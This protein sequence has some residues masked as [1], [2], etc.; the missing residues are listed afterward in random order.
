MRLSIMEILLL[1]HLDQRGCEP[2]V[3][4]NVRGVSTDT[5]SLKNADLFV[6]LRGEN[7]DGHM[8]I[9]DAEKKGALAAVVDARG[10]ATYSGRLPLLV[11]DDT[12]A[13]LGQLASMYRGKFAIPLLAIGGS[14]GKTTTKEMIAA[15]LREKYAVHATE[16]NFNNH[17]GVSMTLLRLT[18]RHD[19]AVVE[20]GTNHPGELKALCSM[21]R[22]TMALL[23]NI[24]REHLEFFGSIEGVEEEEG[25]LFE[26]LRSTKQAVAFVNT[27]DAR[28][29]RCLPRR[30]KAVRYGFSARTEIRGTF[31]AGQA[32][33]VRR[34]GA[35]RPLRIGLP[36]PGRHNAQNAL[37]AVAVGSAL[38]V[39]GSAMVKALEAFRPMSKRMEVLQLGGVTVLNDCYNANPD[40]MMEALHTL[41]MHPAGGKKIAVL[42][43]MLELGTQ[44]PREHVRVGEE[45]GAL[46]ID[47][48][49]TFGELSKNINPGRQKITTYHYDQ[50]NILAEYLAE[51]ISPGDVVL[52]KGSRGMKLED[53]L[54]F[55]IERLRGTKP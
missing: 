28:V 39:P 55:L 50:K 49:L 11:V 43:D 22:P 47:F 52:L 16:A 44:G 1:P 36:L 46:G 41:A 15:V 20:L 31:S 23:T 42:G 29:K 18:G 37:A 48:L 27:D 14:N 53:V 5:R 54:S 33:T 10:A 7:F 51:L 38:R 25:T 19:V 12:I 24:G 8:F 32:L 3:R 45:S 40:S 9:G 30:V 13:T 4:K 2:I 26:S 17:I 21:V 35:S 6:A 34:A